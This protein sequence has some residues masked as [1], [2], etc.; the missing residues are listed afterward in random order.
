MLYSDGL[1]D[2]LTY[3]LGTS[4]YKL[5]VYIAMLYLERIALRLTK[6]VVLANLS[7]MHLMQVSLYLFFFLYKMSHMLQYINVYMP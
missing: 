7:A 1:K 3:T 4:Y 5:L 6:T 2:S